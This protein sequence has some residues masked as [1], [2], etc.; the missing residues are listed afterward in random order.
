MT[1]VGDTPYPTVT[2]ANFPD[3]RIKGAGVSRVNSC[4]EAYAVAN[5]FPKYG[6][7]GIWPTELEAY[8]ENTGDAWGIHGKPSMPDNPVPQYYYSMDYN[9]E[10]PDL[11]TTW[12]ADKDGELPLPMF[13]IGCLR[14]VSNPSKAVKRNRG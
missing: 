5:G 14:F 8:I 9:A 11:A 2:K 7:K 13:S 3:L 6:K 4:Y 12:E 10:T 1:G